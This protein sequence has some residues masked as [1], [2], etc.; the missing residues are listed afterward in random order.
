[1]HSGL[2]E[3]HR[4]LD[5]AGELHKQP[6]LADVLRR[7]PVPADDS[8]RHLGLVGDL[9]RQLGPVDAL[10]RQPGLAGV[11]HR[12]VQRELLDVLDVLQSRIILVSFCLIQN[13][14]KWYKN[15]LTIGCFLMSR[16]S[17]HFMRDNRLGP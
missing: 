14:A 12:L 1:M 4:Q 6:V 15:Q 5:P 13:K 11:L 7:R 3:S 2:H 10:R 17:V 8:H 16:R 9:H